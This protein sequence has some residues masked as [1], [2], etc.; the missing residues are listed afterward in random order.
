MIYQNLEFHNVA[1][2]KQ[3]GNGLRMY[4]FPIDVCNAMGSPDGY[5]GRY[6]SQ[7]TTGCEI[8]FVTEGDRALI[9]LTAT[10]Q[11]GFVQ[12]YRGDFRYYS[13]YVY[14][15][16]VKKGQTTHIELIKAPNF[17]KIDPSLKRKP[18]GFSPDVWR[19]MSDVNFVMTMVDFESYGF[20][21]RPPRPD[22]VPEKTL[23]CYGT[24]L[25]YGACASAQSICYSQLLGR[26]LN[27]N[28]LN[29]AMG[30]SCKNEPE[31]ADYFAS[32]DIHF[33]AILLENGVNMGIDYDGYLKRTTYLLDQ[34]TEKKPDVPIFMVTAYPNS[35]ISAPGCAMPVQKKTE[36]IEHIG[37]DNIIR[38]FPAK[39]PQ[40]RLIEGAEMMP[41]FTALT[42]DGI[43]LSDYGHI[44]TATNLT[45]E[46]NKY[47]KR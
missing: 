15:F 11:E 3:S 40:V 34:L 33:D 8:R 39:Y 31:V 37:T 20:N 32:D 42:C 9:S 22:E 13:G 5:Y 44:L 21:V 24:S 27:V 18:G 28:L 10:D 14:N 23:L 6:V 35:C 29:K 1:E 17:E 25:T 26:M 7:T 47:W 46:I 19:I 16:P 36:V 38:T 41:E 45:R 4:R 43:H 2:V 12:V 30:G